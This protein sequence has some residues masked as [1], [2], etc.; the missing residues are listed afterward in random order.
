MSAVTRRERKLMPFGIVSPVACSLARRQLATRKEAPGNVTKKRRE[1]RDGCGMRD[2]DPMRG[3]EEECGWWEFGLMQG[4]EEECGTRDQSMSGEISQFMT[5]SRIPHSNSVL[6]SY[7]TSRIPFL[8]PASGRS[9]AFLF[10]TLHRVEVPHSSSAPCI[11]SRSRIRP[12]ASTLRSL[13]VPGELPRP[14]PRAI[15]HV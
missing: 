11:G 7:P 8:H 12:Q 2:F 3:A 5:W 9:P 6:N 4:A 13:P 14:M 15:G 10:R 1:W